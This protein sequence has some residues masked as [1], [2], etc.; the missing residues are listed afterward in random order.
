MRKVFGVILSFESGQN[1]SEPFE[2]KM[3][4]VPGGKSA[5][6]SHP[7]RQESYDIK[8]GELEIYLNDRWNTVK[9]CQRVL[10]PQA[11]KHAFRNTGTK[12]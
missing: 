1:P 11:T 4:L 8:E 5:L 7:R 9:A 2:M 12:K 6:H 3:Q 10:I